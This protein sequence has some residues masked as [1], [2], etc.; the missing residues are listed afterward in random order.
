MGG[1]GVDYGDSFFVGLFLENFDPFLK[2]IF[3]F[4]FFFSPILVHCLKALGALAISINILISRAFY[5]GVF[6]GKK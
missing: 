6:V 1:F 3:V 2:G 5:H 4:F